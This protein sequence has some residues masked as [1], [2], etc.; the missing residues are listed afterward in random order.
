MDKCNFMLRKYK[1]GANDSNVYSKKQ[2]EI[3]WI[4]KEVMLQTIA[5]NDEA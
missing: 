4:D 1:K 2:A 3:D 5:E